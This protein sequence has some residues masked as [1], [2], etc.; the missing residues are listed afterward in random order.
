MAGWARCDGVKRTAL[1]ASLRV[2]DCE[3]CGKP[4]QQARSMQAVCSPRCAVKLPKVKARREKAADKAKREEMMTLSEW[5]EAVKREFHRWV[6]LR[7]HGLPC[8]C[9]GKPMEPN[10]P[11]GSVDAGHY[12]SV[13]S[14]KHLR[15]VE[16]NVNAQRKSCNR[17]GGTTRTSFRAGMVARYGEEG[18]AAL[19]ADHEP[20]RYRIH[21]LRA[22]RDDYRARA[23]A[24]A[25]ALKDAA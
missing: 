10:K 19:E 3:T 21:D 15:F 5:G 23:N 4:F 7:D 11:G 9:C 1:T 6:R 18:V 16:M 22:M 17:P 25:K 20:R 14:S 24:L 8:I 13:G 2:R 12:L